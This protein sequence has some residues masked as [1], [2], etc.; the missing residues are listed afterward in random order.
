MSKLH[1]FDGLKSLLLVDSSNSEWQWTPLPLK[2]EAEPGIAP[3]DAYMNVGDVFRGVQIRA[4]AIAKMPRHFYEIT[5]GNEIEVDDP[6]LKV[7]GNL[8]DTLWRIESSL[9]FYGAAYLA[10]LDKATGAMRWFNTA[11]IY[12]R[13]LPDQGLIGF[14]RASPGQNFF[15]LDAMIYIWSPSPFSE[16]GPGPGAVRVALEEAGVIRGVNKALSSYFER[17]MIQPILLYTEEPL[18]PDQKNDL[19]TWFQRMFSGVKRAFTTRILSRK[20]TKLDLSSSLKDAYPLG[21]RDEMCKSI[22]KTLGI[23]FSMLFSD[24]A[25]YATAQQ[26]EKNFYEQAVIPDC[27]LIQEALNSQLFRHFGFELYFA[28]DELPAFQVNSQTKATGLN[29]LIAAGVPIDV[30]MDGMGYDLDEEDDARV[31]LIALMKEG[32]SY[33]AA[34][35]YILAD[36][37]PNEI[38]RVAKVLDL[39]APKPVAPITPVEQLYTAP[40]SPELPSPAKADLLRWQTKALKRL[41]AGKAPACEF[42]SDYIS[43]TLSGAIA[44]ALDTATTADDVRCAFRQ[45]LIWSQYP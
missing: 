21:I 10:K 18:S 16:L 7:I 19:E 36:C 6:R 40:Q 24:A 14:N 39:F 5:G 42:E 8:T 45:S 34:R 44:G 38:E 26:D 3:A 15:G 37:D 17:G 11:T 4:N 2:A 12:P 43:D 28:P 25:N 22:A 1:F 33:D 27:M 31:H 29:N 20:L 41:K 23:P 35:T 13:W 32:A 30:A 9:L